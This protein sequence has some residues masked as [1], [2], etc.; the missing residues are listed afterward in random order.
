[1]QENYKIYLLADTEY[2]F[3]IIHF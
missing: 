3:I 2:T 1:L